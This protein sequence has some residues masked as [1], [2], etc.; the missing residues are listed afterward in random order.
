MWGGGDKTSTKKMRGGS[1]DTNAM[2]TRE[3]LAKF[4][5]PGKKLA[6][7]YNVFLGRINYLSN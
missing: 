4:E 2:L 6:R 3:K 1:V 5:K 7:K